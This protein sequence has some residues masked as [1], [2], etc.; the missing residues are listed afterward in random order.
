MARGLGPMK[1]RRHDSSG[2]PTA[3]QPAQAA[4]CWGSALVNEL[5]RSMGPTGVGARDSCSGN[6]GVVARERAAPP[7]AATACSSLA[8][9]SSSNAEAGMPSR[10]ALIWRRGRACGARQPSYTSHLLKCEG[11]MVGRG[12][13]SR[14]HGGCSKGN[15][16]KPCEG[17]QSGVC[18]LAS[19]GPGSQ[20]S[21]TWKATTMKRTSSRIPPCTSSSPRC[22]GATMASRPLRWG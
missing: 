21:C 19:S 7:E 1:Q 11:V 3:G 5:A 12:R 4:D 13:G 6:S 9:G 17:K 18:C 22:S 16:M 14:Q 10:P 20:P 2:R 8:T 15:R